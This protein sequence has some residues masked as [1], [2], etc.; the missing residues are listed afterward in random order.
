MD[1]IFGIYD[2]SRMKV[3][4]GIGIFLG[5]VFLVYG[6]VLNQMSNFVTIK[7]QDLY[8]HNARF[9]SI[10]VNRYNLLTYNKQDGSKVGCANSFSE[11]EI[12]TMFAQLRGLGITTVRFWLFQSFTDSGEDLSRFDYVLRIAEKYDIWVIPVLENHWHNCTEGEEKS[13]SWYASGYR[14]AY[15]SYPLSFKAYIKKIVP[16]YKNNP[17][18]LA[19]EIMNEAQSKDEKAL[20]AFVNDISVSIKSLDSNHLVMSGVKGT[21]SKMP[22]VDI[23]DYH[24]YDQERNPLPAKLVSVMAVSN[25]INKPFVVGE[26]GIKRSFGDRQS[27]FEAKIHAFFDQGGDIYMLWSYGD[28]YI[29]DDGFN[30]TPSDPLAGV[31]KNASGSIKKVNKIS[32]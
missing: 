24:D 28:T 20:Y 16:V 9:R 12:D 25:E 6:I 31:V 19:W 23:L 5:I 14:S 4:L 8:L 22:T 13:A 32:L 27:L 11:H 30:F 17:T 2:R 7:G 15:G 21:L 18:I 26:S 1:S 10:G 3:L 29:I